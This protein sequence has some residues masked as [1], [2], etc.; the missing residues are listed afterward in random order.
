MDPAPIALFVYNRPEHTR[1][2]VEALQKN[3]LA[4]ESDFFIYSDGSKDESDKKKIQ[5]VRNYLKTIEGFKKITIIERDRNLGLADN[6][7]SGVTEIVNKY[8]YI[9]VLEDDIVTSNYFLQYMNNALDKYKN[10]E[11]VMHLAAYMPAM[12]TAGLPESFFLRQSSCWGW[13]TWARAWKYFHRDGKK[14]IE[15]FCKEDIF[16]FNLD[17]CYDYWSQLL[18]NEKGLLKTWAVYWYAC[19]FNRKG[20]CLHPRD[21][22]VQN[23][24]F[25]GSGE[26]CGKKLKMS[27]NLANKKVLHF[28]S[29]DKDC[30]ENKESIN[31]LKQF[32][33]NE[34]MV[35]KKN[36]LQRFKNVIEKLLKNFNFGLA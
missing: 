26:N 30:Y 14:Y 22:L 11:Q 4:K 21:S 17:G 15:N 1:F 18:A 20:L 28:A 9:I 8:R 3:H 33:L 24:G 6:I 10:V 27:I 19:V 35:I 7:V 36:K 29:I 5:E 2:T 34:K 16:R 13:A 12:E 25:D 32:L 31:R 23:I